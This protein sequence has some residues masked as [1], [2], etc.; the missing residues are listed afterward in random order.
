MEMPRSA[1]P[2]AGTILAWAVIC[3]S[4][5]SATAAPNPTSGRATT[6]A[7]RAVAV[8][9]ATGQPDGIA[10]AR[11]IQAAVAT[12]DQLA[13]LGDAATAALTGPLDDEDAANLAAA[14]RALADARDAVAHFDRPAALSHAAAGQARLLSASPG[15]EAVSLLADLMFVEGLAQATDGDVAAAVEAFAAVR[16]LDP[17]RTIDPLKFLPD[18]VR[19]FRAA[20]QPAGR[21]SIAATIDGPGLEVWVDGN[22]IGA[23]PAVVSAPAGIHFVVA[24]G[25]DA[26]SVGA[27]LM[28]TRDR[29]SSITLITAAASPALRLARLRRRLVAAPDDAARAAAIASLAHA[30]AVDDAVLVVRAPG[31][32]LGVRVWR[33]QAPGLGPVRFAQ[34][35]IPR[36][37][38]PAEALAPLAGGA[39]VVEPPVRRPLVS[40]R[41]DPPQP[42]WRERWARAGMVGGVVAVVAGVAAVIAISDPGRTT[43]GGV[44][45]E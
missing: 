17:D 23:A 24:T 9:D 22:R 18:V 30:T 33:N 27:R 11:D 29:S 41:A 7:R 42:W 1:T 34:G 12:S 38:W 20:G 3:A 45:V 44:V 25:P 36:D 5:G 13:P 6:P 19:A 15:R 39:R 43:L 32:R 40:R 37:R 16:R 21:G 8:V 2:F 35:N 31:D 4:T 28:V 14:R 26:I 10:L